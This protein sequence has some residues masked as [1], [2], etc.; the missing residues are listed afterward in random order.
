MYYREN[1]VLKGWSKLKLLYSMR[2]QKKACD[3]LTLT[4]G[5]LVH[6]LAI[7]GL[8]LAGLRNVSPLAQMLSHL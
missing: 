7:A 8:W 6:V 3:V 4:A 5:F 1:K 2:L